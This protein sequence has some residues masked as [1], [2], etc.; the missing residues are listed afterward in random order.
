[1]AIG[2]N[3][4]SSHWWLVK[5]I[6]LIINYFTDRHNYINTQ[7]KMLHCKWMQMDCVNSQTN[8]IT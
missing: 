5:I 2:D 6:N 1:M 7:S 3:N 4:I 8:W